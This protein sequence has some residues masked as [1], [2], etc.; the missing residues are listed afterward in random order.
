MWIFDDALVGYLEMP[1]NLFE[2]LEVKVEYFETTSCK[3]NG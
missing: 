2:E 1:L 3:C